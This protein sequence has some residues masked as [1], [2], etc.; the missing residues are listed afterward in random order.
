MAKTPEKKVKD[1]CVS[2]LKQFDCYYFY[3]VTGGYGSSGIPDIIACL[4]GNFIGIEC[5]AGTNKPTALQLSNLEKIKTAGGTALVVN[6]DNLE[7]L[8]RILKRIDDNHRL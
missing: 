7:H 1:K 2:I 4:H 8:H 3:P 5:K 6:E